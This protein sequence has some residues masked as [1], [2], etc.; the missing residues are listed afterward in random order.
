MVL[1]VLAFRGTLM[2][3]YCLWFRDRTHNLGI[4]V[5]MTLLRLYILARFSTFPL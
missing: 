4:S 5:R 1:Q 3:Y 2:L